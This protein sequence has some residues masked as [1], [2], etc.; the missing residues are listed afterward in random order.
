MGKYDHFCDH[1]GKRQAIGVYWI[2]GRPRPLALCTFCITTLRS[3]G[4]Q[5][6]VVRP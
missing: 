6:S 3:I 4:R 2:S 1:C 5:L